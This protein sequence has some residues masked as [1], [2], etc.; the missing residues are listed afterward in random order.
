MCGFM[1]EENNSQYPKLKVHNRIYRNISFFN[2]L[3]KLSHNFKSVCW[4]RIW[5]LKQCDRKVWVKVQY[6][7]FGILTKT[8]SFV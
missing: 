8:A 5:A 2:I 1:D 7:H 6:R 4:I 3:P